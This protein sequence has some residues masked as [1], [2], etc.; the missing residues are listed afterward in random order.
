MIYAEFHPGMFLFLPSVAVTHGTC[1]DPAC[2]ADH[3]LITAGW[4]IGSIHFCF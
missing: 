3:W 2:A 1:S 4:L